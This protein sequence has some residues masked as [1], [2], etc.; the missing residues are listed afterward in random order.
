MKKLYLLTSVCMLLLS[1]CLREDSDPK[2]CVESDGQQVKIYKY[3]GVRQCEA[4]SGISLE[5]MQN[6]LSDAGID[7]ICAAV[8]NDGKSYITLCG[9]DTGTINTYVIKRSNLSDA[10]QLGFKPLSEMENK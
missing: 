7:V 9:A 5:D 8:G 6:E 2:T 1:A 4:D 3:A 10:E